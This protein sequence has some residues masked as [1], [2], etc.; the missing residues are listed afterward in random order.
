M[1]D[2]IEAAVNWWADK[3]AGGHFQDNGDAYQSVFATLARSETSAPTD[4]QLTA[5]RDRLRDE[6]GHAIRSHDSWRIDE[7][8]WGGCT[9]G[10]C[11]STDYGPEPL[12]RR[13]ADAAGIND[14]RFP[15]KT[16]MWI[17]PGQVK[18][19]CGYGKPAEVIYP[20]PEREGT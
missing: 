1:E 8:M 19:A 5:F 11:V 14:M 12:L 20:K 18:V 2:E 6:I 17:S 4:D 16:V 15:I 9:E 10:R 13:S 3:L 7:P